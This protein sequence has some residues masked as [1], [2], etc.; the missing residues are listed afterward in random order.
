MLC[1]G[2]LRPHGSRQSGQWRHLPPD[3]RG[4]AYVQFHRTRQELRRIHIEMKIAPKIVNLLFK[5]IC[6]ELGLKIAWIV[7]LCV[8]VL[9][10]A[11]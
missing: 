8:L 7:A 1:P 11:S 2:T 6:S 9:F 10:V 5:G 4:A 3:Q